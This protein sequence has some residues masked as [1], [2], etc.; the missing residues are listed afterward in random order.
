VLRKRPQSEIGGFRSSKRSED[1][2]RRAS[3][4]FNDW[5]DSIA[6]CPWPAH[7]GSHIESREKSDAG[8]AALYTPEQ[9]A[10]RDASP[11]TLVQA[12]LAPLQFIVFA[13][14]LGLVIR[15]L[16]TGEGYALA[17]ASILAKTFL[18]YLIMITGSI[19]E[20]EVFGKYLFARA[21]FWEDVFSMLVL[22]LQTAYLVSL[23][24]GWGTAQQQMMIAV[25]AYAAYIINAGQFLMKLRE[26]R[27]EAER[28]SMGPIR[29]DRQPA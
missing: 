21:F 13:V 4:F 6:P 16:M 28:S 9:R 5:I 10:K 3:N 11:W 15:F 7:V 2:E 18:L 8:K 19:W 1:R 14:S 26:A 17:T 23:L 24:A 20:K 27:L 29:A 22:A 25:A 12:I